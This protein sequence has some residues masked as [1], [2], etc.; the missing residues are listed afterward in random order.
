MNLTRVSIAA[1]TVFHLAFATVLACRWTSQHDEILAGRDSIQSVELLA[2]S[3]PAEPP[4][5]LQSPSPEPEPQEIETAATDVSSQRRETFPEAKRAEAMERLLLEQSVS[6]RPE[7][8][9]AQPPEPVAHAAPAESPHVQRS[10]RPPQPMVHSAAA[11][12]SKDLGAVSDQQPAKVTPPVFVDARPPAVPS[13]ARRRG[14]RGVVMLMITVDE[15]GLVTEVELL[16]SSGHV[17][18]DNA[19]VQ[20]VRR[21]RGRPAMR[22]GT[23]FKSTWKK[24]IRFE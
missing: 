17:A 6:A 7:R 5:T 20:A 13:E 3:S 15:R 24:P 12:V 21:W 10:R 2:F 14:W 1:S 16:K 11:A 22:G 8:K 19:A 4:V 23:P 18:L 9:A